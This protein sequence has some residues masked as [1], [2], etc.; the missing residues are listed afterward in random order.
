MIADIMSS[1]I[2]VVKNIPS[3]SP[4]F[5]PSPIHMKKFRGIIGTIGE[6]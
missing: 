2:Y 3:I 4:I 6:K 5:T 1:I